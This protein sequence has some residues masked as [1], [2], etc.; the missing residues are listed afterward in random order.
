MTRWDVLYTVLFSINFNY[1]A[2]QLKAFLFV[3][4]LM[5][6][7]PCWIFLASACYVE[8]GVKKNVWVQISGYSNLKT[9]V[10]VLRKTNCYWLQFNKTYNCSSL[11]LHKESLIM[12]YWSVC[13]HVVYTNKNIIT[14]T[15]KMKTSCREIFVSS[16]N[17]TNK[18]Q[19]KYLTCKVN[20]MIDMNKK[21]SS[22]AWKSRKI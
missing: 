13:K 15:L 10:K 16:E 20:H 1:L 21:Q 22:F 12:F 14:S 3:A 7:F 19:V 6:C 5:K 17:I 9:N 2:V 4:K 18:A 11:M 8:K